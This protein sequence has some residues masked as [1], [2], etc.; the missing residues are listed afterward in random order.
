MLIDVKVL[1][2]FTIYILGKS[3]QKLVYCSDVTQCNIHILNRFNLCIVL[4]Y[5]SK[6]KLKFLMSK[7]E[8]LLLLASVAEAIRKI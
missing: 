7:K 2:T 4:T 1:V 3:L 8:D 6:L 5:I